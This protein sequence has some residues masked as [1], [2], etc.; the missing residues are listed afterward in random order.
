[1]VFNYSLLQ[2]DFSLRKIAFMADTSETQLMT[3]DHLEVENEIVPF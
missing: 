3:P 1:M 2:E